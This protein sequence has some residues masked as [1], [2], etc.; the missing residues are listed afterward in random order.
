MRITSIESFQ[1]V[2]QK[3]GAWQQVVF[4][5]ILNHPY[6]TDREIALFLGVTDPNV[7]RPRRKELLDQNIIQDYGVRECSVSKKKAHI[8]AVN[9][10]VLA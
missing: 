7:V 1:Q 6:S 5:T 10:E 8:W 9:C 3:L 4:T 2:Q